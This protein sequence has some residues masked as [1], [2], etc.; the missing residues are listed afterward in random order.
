MLEFLLGALV[1][2][3]A[4]EIE[5]E[6]VEELKLFVILK[7]VLFLDPRR[8]LRV[9]CDLGLELFLP[10]DLAVEHP[11]GQRPVLRWNSIDQHQ[12]RESVAPVVEAPA[13]HA[14]QQPAVRMTPLVE[15]GRSPAR[16]R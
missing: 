7:Q 8:S 10:R 15:F 12:I 11:N 6:R 13:M 14:R 5:R 2:M 4:V 16:D 3:N 9:F 1:R